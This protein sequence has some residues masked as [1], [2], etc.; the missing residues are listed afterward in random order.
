MSAQLT[1]TNPNK[2]LYTYMC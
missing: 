1:P 2:I